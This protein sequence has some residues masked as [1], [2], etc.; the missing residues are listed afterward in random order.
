MP[1]WHDVFGTPAATCSQKLLLLHA[2]FAGTPGSRT[3]SRREMLVGIFDFWLSFSMEACFTLSG[4]SVMAGVLLVLLVAIAADS[5]VPPGTDKRE[6][7]C[8]AAFTGE[9]GMP[10]VEVLLSL[11]LTM[12]TAATASAAGGSG[13]PFVWRPLRVLT[14]ALLAMVLAAA[15]WLMSGA[16]CRL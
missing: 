16:M 13:L 7:R 9:H 2:C 4:V 15:V 5:T 6:L 10:Y 3:A 11:Y 1:S 8:R 14:G 12:W